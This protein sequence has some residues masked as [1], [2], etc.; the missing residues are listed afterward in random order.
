MRDNYCDKIKASAFSFILRH[1]KPA[2][3]QTR[4][5]PLLK[6][7]LLQ[8]EAIRKYFEAAGLQGIPPLIEWLY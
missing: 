7:L 6:M 3:S 8:D 2:I 4:C 1:S 5:L